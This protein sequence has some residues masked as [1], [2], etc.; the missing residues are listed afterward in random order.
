MRHI[1]I[2]PA[3][4]NSKGLKKK[5]RILIDGCLK[6]ITKIKWFNQIIIS[7][8]DSLIIN[9]AKENNLD[10]IKRSK[11]LSTGNISIKS[12]M[13][14]V[15]KKKN[16]DKNTVIWLIYLPLIGKKKIYFDNAKKII[17]KNI[18]RSICSFVPVKS[19]PYNSWY[20]KGKKMVRLFNKDIYRRQDLPKMWEHNHLICAFKV[21]ELN[22]LNSELIN[23]NTIPIIF[24]KKI[25]TNII[26]VDYKE[27]L[28]KININNV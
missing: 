20:L 1:A 10:F 26:E 6:F 27:D 12:V 8:D 22:K 19:H 2:I 28:K 13:I 15:V 5:N 24:D 21:K 9:K 3:R 25:A 17:E 7:S 14:D 23:K 11:K 4:K 16:L 18:T